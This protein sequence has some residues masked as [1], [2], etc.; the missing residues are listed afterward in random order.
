MP[1]INMPGGFCWNVD[2]NF[3]AVTITYG[4][5]ENVGDQ[6]SES[7]DIEV[8]VNGGNLN[9]G[10]TEKYTITNQL[11]PGYTLRGGTCTIQLPRRITEKDF[12]V[13]WISYHASNNRS[14][15][16]DF[17]GVDGFITSSMVLEQG[18]TKKQ[19]KK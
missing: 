15:S 18:W 16:V 5:L 7:I 17:E 19:L 8:S 11:L 3:S 4:W 13:M 10:F 2:K 9:G 12:F 1:V 6:E 14:G